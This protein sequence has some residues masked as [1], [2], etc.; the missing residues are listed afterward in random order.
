[1]LRRP[2]RST[3]PYTLF[4]YTTLFR[5]R[6]VPRIGRVEAEVVETRIVRIQ[7]AHLGAEHGGLAQQR[8]ALEL[9]ALDVQ[10]GGVEHREGAHVLRHARLEVAVVA[11]ER[12]H[13]AAQ[14]VV[15]GD[16]KSTRL[17]SS[18]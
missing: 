11:L 7:P 4:P 3:R 10:L 12:R 17:N 5:S 6:V 8:A 13:A 18:H 1:M 2:P 9:D 16:R 15:G 14:P